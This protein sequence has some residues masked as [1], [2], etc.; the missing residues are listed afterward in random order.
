MSFLLALSLLVGLLSGGLSI[1]EFF[2]NQPRRSTIFAIIA[3]GLF[4]GAFFL[5]NVPSL[6]ANNNLSVSGTS[7]PNTQQTGIASSTTQ[8][9]QTSTSAPSPT[10]TQAPSLP[11]LVN[12]GTWTGGTSDWK[13]LNGMLLNDGT[14]YMGTGQNGPTIVAPCQLQGTSDY[15]V[16][17]KM[18]VVSTASFQGGTCF[19]IT[20]RGS[21]T[22]D[23]WQGYQGD[24]DIDG[25]SSEGGHARI[26][27]KQ[28]PNDFS[29]ARAP[30][31]PGTA[32]HI[33][34]VEVKGNSIQFII[35][36]LPLVAVNDNQYLTGGQVGLW[37]Y[38]V[39]L[40]VSSF[41]IIAL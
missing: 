10:P 30:F 7:T 34:R 29:L 31:S 1:Y 2:K 22:T 20:V 18:Q 14:R 21:S 17:A 37:S 13:S 6:F 38:G 41:K 9:S 35:D 11:C 40:N 28:F 26:L 27:G 24:I 15:A 32:W 4:V 19:G 12:L 39:Q 23:S 36:G 25:C 5:G 3:L 16:E 8:V 33:Y